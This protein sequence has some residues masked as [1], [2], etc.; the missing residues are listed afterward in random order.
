V[1]SQ[2]LTSP[3][4]SQPGTRRQPSKFLS[5]FRFK[6]VKVTNAST[7][8]MASEDTSQCW[9]YSQDN[10]SGC[11]QVGI[12][13]TLKCY[14]FFK[15][16]KKLRNENC[17]IDATWIIELYEQ[18]N[19]INLSF[20]V[21]RLNFQTDY[22]GLIQLTI[23]DIRHYFIKWTTVFRIIRLTTTI[24]QLPRTMRNSLFDT[25]LPDVL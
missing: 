9:E 20:T 6:S 21:S 3:S 1:T 13:S 24:W 2:V 5:R 11:L 7:S 15:H 4:S 14:F 17:Y 10:D 16:E 12:T 22:S 8:A 19:A 23:C 18:C 25:N